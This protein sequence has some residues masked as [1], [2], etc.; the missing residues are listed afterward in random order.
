LLAN[1]LELA[2]SASSHRAGGGAVL[3]F[4]FIPCSP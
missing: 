1:P 3:P 4:S 2:L